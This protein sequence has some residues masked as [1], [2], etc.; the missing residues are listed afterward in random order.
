[1]SLRGKR[2]WTMYLDVPRI[3]VALK[4]S[5]SINFVS[6]R[7]PHEAELSICHEFGYFHSSYSYILQDFGA[8]HSVGW[9]CRLIPFCCRFFKLC[10][11]V[12][13]VFSSSCCCV[14]CWCALTSCSWGGFWKQ[15]L[16]SFTRVFCERNVGNSCHFALGTVAVMIVK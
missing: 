1:M 4:R 2:G 10:P 13:P 8:L 16:E 5:G 7:V 3:S 6:P 12:Q 11:L 14:F 9:H 15:L